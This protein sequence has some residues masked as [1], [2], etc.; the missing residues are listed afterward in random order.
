MRDTCKD[1][2]NGKGLPASENLVLLLLATRGKLNR[3]LPL[4]L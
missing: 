1:K 4:E 3:S 2:A